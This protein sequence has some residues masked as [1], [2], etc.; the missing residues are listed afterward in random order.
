MSPLKVPGAQLLYEM[1]ESGPL[2]AL[3]LGTSGTGESLADISAFC[4]SP[5]SL[6]RHSW[7]RSKT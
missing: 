5:P 2:L 1:G 4:P 3:I 6:H 7:T